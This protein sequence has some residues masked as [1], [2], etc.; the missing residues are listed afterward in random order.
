MGVDDSMSH[1]NYNQQGFEENTGDALPL[2]ARRL[3][4]EQLRRSHSKVV[5]EE[6]IEHQEPKPPTLKI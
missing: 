3:L 2:K 1:R 6:I 5:L 4:E